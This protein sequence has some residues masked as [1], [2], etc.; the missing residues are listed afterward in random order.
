[1]HEQGETPSRC[2]APKGRAPHPAAH[3][4]DLRA[5]AQGLG[6]GLGQR[7]RG[8]ILVAGEGIQRPPQAIAVLAVHRLDLA[9]RSSHASHD[10]GHYACIGSDRRQKVTGGD[11]LLCAGRQEWAEPEQLAEARTAQCPKVAMGRRRTALGRSLLLA[12]RGRHRAGHATATDRKL[13]KA[14]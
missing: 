1:M 10:G 5:T 14:G 7:I 3:I 12:D 2:W 6:K 11:K 8:D 13:I 4:P 9:S